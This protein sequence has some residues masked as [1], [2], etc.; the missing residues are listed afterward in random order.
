MIGAGHNTD[1]SRRKSQWQILP[2]TAELSKG[3]DDG[4]LHP[5]QGRDQ[6]DRGGLTDALV[7]HKESALNDGS[8][9]NVLYSLVIFDLRNAMGKR[10]RGL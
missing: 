6:V 9:R 2:A 7:P 3:A 1:G 4:A 10:G 5:C 8:R